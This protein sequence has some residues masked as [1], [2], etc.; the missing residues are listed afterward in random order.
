MI[1]ILTGMRIG[2]LQSKL[3]LVKLLTKYE[4]SPCKETQIPLRISPKILI[5]ASESGIFLKVKELSAK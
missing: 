1:F 2:L 5:T 3:G 4:F